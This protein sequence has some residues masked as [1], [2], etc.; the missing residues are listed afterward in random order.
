MILPGNNLAIPPGNMD[1]MTMVWMWFKVTS[2]ARLGREDE[3][4]GT[5]S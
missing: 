1:A 2:K 5:H 3:K 4:Q